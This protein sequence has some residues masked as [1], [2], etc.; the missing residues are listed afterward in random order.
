MPILVCLGHWFALSQVI[1]IIS[2]AISVIWSILNS[3]ERVA[4][5]I[6]QISCLIMDRF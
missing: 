1:T 2:E 4:S 6:I 3:I 5:S